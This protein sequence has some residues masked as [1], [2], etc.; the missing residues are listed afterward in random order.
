M[1]IVLVSD[2]HLA[3]IAKVFEP[4]WRAAK[5]LAATSRAELTIHLGDISL[6]GAC[7]PTH[8]E[9]A[10]AL[11]RDWPTPIR[12]LPGNHDIGDNPWAPGLP[13]EH[14]LDIDRLREYRAR[15]G[16]DYWALESDGWWIVGLDAQLFATETAAEAEQW[17]WLEEIVA[18]LRGSPVAILL[19]KP[20]F[21]NHPGDAAPHIR[22][23]PLEP[24]RRLLRLISSID[25][26]VVLSGHTHQY[27][28]RT[29]DGLRHIWVPSS[30][31]VFP[32]SMQERIGEKL[33]GL[34]LLELTP[35]RYQFDLVCA[36]GMEQNDLVDHPAVRRAMK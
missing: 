32:D 36:D 27:L 24:R 26:R 5:R 7:D 14:P 33:N 22:Y 8:L 3:P 9:Y 17:T 13:N 30:A 12:F 19:H 18:S 6:D 23:V 10:H 21:Q 35:N 4:N 1:R 29:I 11:S 15:F 16:P 31:F 25:A 20:L 2:S 34:G 28:E